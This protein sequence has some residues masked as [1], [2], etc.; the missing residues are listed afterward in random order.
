MSQEIWDAYDKDGNPLGFELV[1]GKLIKKGVFHIVVEIYPI[2]ENN[3]VLITK[4]HPDK[5]WGLKWE[6]PGGSIIKGETPEEGAIR[7]LKEETGIE[8]KESD[9]HFVYSYLYKDIPVI[10]KCFIVFIN[11]EKTIIRLQEGETIDYRYLPY[12]EFKKFILS[13]NY[14]DLI[15]ERFSAHEKLFDAIVHER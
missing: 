15:R 13:D 14:I 3:E 4:R 2:T 9:L 12:D 5:P 10:C 7:E 11:K 8:V 6:I 1:R